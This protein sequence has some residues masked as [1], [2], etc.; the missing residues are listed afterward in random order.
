[1]VE[2]VKASLEYVNLR[3]LVSLYDHLRFSSSSRLA[4]LSPGLL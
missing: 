4:R 1:M 3:G 2:K